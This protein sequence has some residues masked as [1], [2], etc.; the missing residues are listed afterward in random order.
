MVRVRSRKGCLIASISPLLPLVKR[1]ER[2]GDLAGGARDAILSLP[3]WLRRV[4]AG[5][6][7]VREGDRPDE[8]RL[9]VSGLAFRHKLTGDGARQIV[10][11]HVPGEVIDLH[12]SFLDVADHNVQALTDVEVALIP[13]EVLRELNAA[14]PDVARG[15]LTEALIDASI[16]MEWLLNVSRRDAKTRLGHFI[17]ELALRLRAAGVGEPASYSVPLTQDQMADA[18]GMTQVHLNR[19]LMALGERGLIERDRRSVHILDWQA[20][21]D[22]SDFAPRYLHLRD[23]EQ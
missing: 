10:S 7:L 13:R 9:V 16:L 15:M 5:A 1:L 11:I 3:C 19:M 20:L 6:H 17:C 14:H 2:H 18:L 23:A 8:S 4:K 21:V 22:F 12:N